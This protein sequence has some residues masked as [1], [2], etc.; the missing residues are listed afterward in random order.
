[1]LS[2]SDSRTQEITGNPWELKD[3]RDFP[4]RR[5]GEPVGIFG[6]FYETRETQPK[7]MG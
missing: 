7:K 4:D 3:K 5:K 6:K 1:L 2:H